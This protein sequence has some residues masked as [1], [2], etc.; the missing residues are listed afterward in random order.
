MG[1]GLDQMSQRLLK[2][3]NG[4]LGFVILLF[5]KCLTFPIREKAF[6]ETIKGTKGNLRKIKK[7]NPAVEEDFKCETES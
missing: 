4:H 3:G 6:W 7:N 1:W 5:W 2:L